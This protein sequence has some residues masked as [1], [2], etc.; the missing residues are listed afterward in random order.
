MIVCSFCAYQYNFFVKK[1]TIMN[2]K[3]HFI[4]LIGGYSKSGKDYFSE[5]WDNDSS[6]VFYTKKNDIEALKDNISCSLKLK[7][8]DKL[9]EVTNT[10]FEDITPHEIRKDTSPTGYNGTFRDYMIEIAHGVKKI[11]KEIFAK[12]ASKKIDLFVRHMSVKVTDFRFEEEYTCLQKIF[13]DKNEIVTIKVH[14]P[15]IIKFEKTQ[16]E[17]SLDNFCFDYYAFPS[18]CEK[19]C[20]EEMSKTSNKCKDIFEWNRFQMQ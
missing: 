12:L 10:L 19:E 15:G 17:N 5:T 2:D 9:I 14:R 4:F 13:K 20:L 7:F 3:A 1:R 6:Y 18:S 8:A 11:D 16:S